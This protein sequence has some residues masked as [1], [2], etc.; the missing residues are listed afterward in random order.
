MALTTVKPSPAFGMCRSESSTSKSCAT[1]HFSA[2]VTL[3]ALTTSNPSPSIADCNISRT[4]A[5]SS[6]SKILGFVIGLPYILTA[7]RLEKL[8]TIDHLAPDK[9]HLG[10]ALCPQSIAADHLIKLSNFDQSNPGLQSIPYGTKDSF[11]TE[12]GV[13]AG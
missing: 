6:T 9:P 10:A 2:S 11:E 1:M 5:S 3:L 13:R 12:V 7:C 4:D 8:C